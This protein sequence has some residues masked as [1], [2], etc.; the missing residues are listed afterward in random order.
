MLKVRYRISL[1]VLILLLLLVMSCNN[2]GSQEAVAVGGPSTIEENVEDPKGHDAGSLS[3]ELDNLLNTF[4]VSEAGKRSIIRIKDVVTDAGIGSI[5]SYRSY[6]NSELY[7]LLNDLGAAK[8]WEIIKADLELVKTQKEALEAI[9]NVHK[10]KERQSLQVRFDSKKN[11]YPLHLKGLFNESDFN[12]VYRNV[13]GDK[14]VNEFTAI[15]A[16]ATRIIKNG[17]VYELFSVQER[18]A[19]DEIQ[20]IVTDA[21]LVQ[22]YKT[23]S[24]DEFNNLLNSL[25][26][27]KVN[28]MIKAYLSVQEIQREVFDIIN[29]VKD[30]DIKRR[31]QARYDDKQKEYPLHLKR[32][33]SDSIA[34]TVYGRV[35]SDNYVSEFVAIKEKAMQ[36]MGGFDLYEGLPS[37]EKSV[38]D[39]MR[40]IVTDANIGNVSD[41]K[42]YT[43][44]EFYALL[45]SLGDAKIREMIKF[46]LDIFKIREEIEA[47]IAGLTEE[48]VKQALNTRLAD[49]NSEYLLSV[50]GAFGA[51][52][53]DIIYHRFVNNFYINIYKDLKNKVEDPRVL[54]VYTWLSDEGKGVI[55][56]IQGIV[57]DPNLGRAEGY[58][59]YTDSEVNNLLND[60]GDSKTGGMITAYLRGKAIQEIVLKAINAV[61]AGTAKQNLQNRFNAHK[62]GYALHLKGLFNSLS[63]DTV[64]N[65]VVHEKYSDGFLRIQDS[66][67]LIPS[68]TADS[69]VSSN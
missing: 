20:N 43:V 11:E 34:D 31:L 42:T 23:Y 44:P 18:V 64:Y 6:T 68:N 32:L 35:I 10:P 19:I 59:T 66:I 51:S 12:A 52:V 57:T 22:D 30:E 25:G 62:N 9:N 17:D 38:V 15:K 56:E 48:K 69:T 37:R 13:I 50:K 60:L 21:S 1:L 41:Y 53:A 46:N 33:F 5:E 61:S 49:S 2:K 4:G 58:R 8:I 36:V 47:A 14:Y 3:A 7:T 45:N 27:V 29:N 39:F 54:D 26:D 55:D 40:G 28:E 65:N 63:S 67:R 16:E 24:R